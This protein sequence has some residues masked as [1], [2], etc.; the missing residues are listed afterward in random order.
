[1]TRQITT[2]NPATE[3]V[4]N[5]YEIMTKE[6][7]RENA[8]KSLDFWKIPSQEVEQLVLK[9]FGHLV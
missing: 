3:E 6:Q 9:L 5:S 1:M 4:I 7:I 2:I 8:K